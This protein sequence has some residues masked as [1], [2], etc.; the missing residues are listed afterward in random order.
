MLSLNELSEAMQPKPVPRPSLAKIAHEWDA[1]VST[2]LAQIRTGA[3]VTF[4]RVLMPAIRRLSRDADWSNVL[5]AGSGSGTLT[6]RLSRRAAKITGVDISAESIRVARLTYPKIEFVHSSVERFAHS[7]EKQFPLVISN[8]TL[9]CAPNA[10]RFLR[11]VAASPPSGTLRLHD[12]TSLVL[13]K[14][15][16]ISRRQVV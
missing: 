5:D 3:D 10:Q 4:H 16:G 15:L 13:A 1:I 9:M 8:M 12:D 2:R 14:V 7:H 6:S 11:A